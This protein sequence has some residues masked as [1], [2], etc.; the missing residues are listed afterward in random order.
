MNDELLY[1][2]EEISKKLKITKNTVYEM[3]KRGDLDAH[4]LGK[5]LR[6]SQSQFE[7]YLLKSKGSSNQYQGTVFM[8]ADEQFVKVDDI[9]IHVHTELTGEVK[10]S[11]RPE[12][13][14]LSLEPFTSS[15]RN[16]FK[17]VVVDLIEN[18]DGVKV[19]LDIGIP[20]MSLITRKSMNNMHITKG[21]DLYAIFKTM[22]IS[23]YK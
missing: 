18:N 23:V 3:I 22:S 13:I 10:L 5:H 11:I 12:D 8:E 7:N 6:I 9:T 14:I 16:I 17:G 4:R 20:L 19:V 15:A 21:C 1:T 2:P